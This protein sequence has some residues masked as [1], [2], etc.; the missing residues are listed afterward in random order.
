MAKMNAVGEL[1]RTTHARRLGLSE[2]TSWEEMNAY[3]DEKFKQEQ[4]KRR[5]KH[6]QEILRSTNISGENTN[7]AN[8]VPVAS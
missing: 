4:G 3:L 8:L 1:A 6:H 5:T 2:E 7:E